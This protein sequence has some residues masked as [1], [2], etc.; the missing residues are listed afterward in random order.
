MKVEDVKK[1]IESK[2]A[3]ES[4]SESVHKLYSILKENRLKRLE[5]VK[6]K[7]FTKVKA[8]QCTKE[9]AEPAKSSNVK[10]G[11]WLPKRGFLEYFAQVTIRAK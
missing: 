5:C 2:S 3:S 1:Q 7:Y 11:H 9:P 8:T 10:F 6:I 4:T